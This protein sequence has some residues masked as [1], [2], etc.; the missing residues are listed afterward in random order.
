MDASGPQ[1]KRF[2]DDREFPLTA[3]PESKQVQS[4][5]LALVNFSKCAVAALA[6]EAMSRSGE[7]VSLDNAFNFDCKP[8]PD[9]KQ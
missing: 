3:G 6:A 4:L 2:G 1:G 8:P 5:Q 9:R 7:L